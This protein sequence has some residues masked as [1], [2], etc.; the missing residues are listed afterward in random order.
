MNKIIKKKSN[1]VLY[2]I[3]VYLF[4]LT[5]LLFVCFC[6]CLLYCHVGIS[7]FPLL[8]AYLFLLVLRTLVLFYQTW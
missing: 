1:N 2:L 6:L 5:A 4:S 8:F 3:V 7:A